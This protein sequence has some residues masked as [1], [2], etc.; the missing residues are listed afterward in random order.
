MMLEP[1][2]PGWVQRRLGFFSPALSPTTWM[3]IDRITQAILWLI[4]FAILAPILGPRPYGIFSIVMVFIGVTEWILIE[5]TVEAL[6]TVDELDHLHMSTANLAGGGIALGLSLVTSALAP[7]IGTFFHDS[8]ITR[9][10]WVLSPLPVVT[11]LAAVP[12]AILRRS[13]NFKQLAI[14]GIGGLLIGG[15]LGIILALTGAGA[16]ALVAQALGQ[17]VAEF[18]I[19]WMSAP[20]SLDFRWSG[21]HFRELSPVGINV[22]TGR[23]MGFVGGQLPRIIMGYMLGPT[24]LGLFTLANR[25]LDLLTFIAIQPRTAVG[26]IELRHQKPGSAEFQRIFSRMMQNV[27]ILSFPVFCGGT[28][29]TPDLFRIWLDH[30]WMAGVLPTQLM[31][32]SGLPLVFFYCIDAALLAANQSSTFKWLA[33]VQALT[34]TAIVL[35]AAPFGLDLICLAWLVRSLVLLPIFLL[36]FR[37]TCGVSVQSAVQPAARSLIGAIIMA[38]FLSLPFLRVQW[39]R[40]RSDFIFLVVIGI[41]FYMTYLCSFARAEFKSFVRQIFSHS[42]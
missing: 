38:G 37:R 34:M 22:F 6:V 30:R 23:I 5:G 42:S 17:R 26:R 27:S 31:L 39:F 8:E 4:I 40:G 29:L 3:T 1:R 18:I 32:L 16:W 25:F 11:A 14:R 2:T 35:C 10:I 13:F 15:T 9:L 7:T 20:V 36:L 24:T 12:T 21:T 19:L 28:A 41:S 33:S